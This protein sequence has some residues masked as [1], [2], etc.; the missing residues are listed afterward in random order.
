MRLTPASP[1]PSKQCGELIDGELRLLQDSGERARRNRA[2]TVHRDGHHSSGWARMDQHMVAA[3]DMAQVEPSPSQ[4]TQDRLSVDDRKFTRGQEL[5][6]YREGF[7]A[8][9]DVGRRRRDAQS[10][11]KP[12]ADERFLQHRHSSLVEMDRS[13]ALF[14]SRYKLKLSWASRTVKQESSR[15][16]PQGRFLD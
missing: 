6:C 15:R 2:T 13:P 10:K 8:D 9:R 3:A 4:S 5:R 12:C 14:S 7:N 11:G 1:D 16:G